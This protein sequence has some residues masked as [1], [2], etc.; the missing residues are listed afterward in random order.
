MIYYFD[1]PKKKI[2]VRL[3]NEKPE[4]GIT[5]KFKKDELIADMP[6]YSIFMV[7]ADGWYVGNKLTGTVKRFSFRTSTY[8]DVLEY[9]DRIGEV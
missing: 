3:F 8:V 5:M 1:E 6:L 4:G 9:A 2:R 7:I